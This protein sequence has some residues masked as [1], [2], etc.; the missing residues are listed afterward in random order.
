MPAA[1]GSVGGIRRFIDISVPRN[2]APDIT[3]AVN[4]RVFNVDDLKEVVSKNKEERKKAAD[5]AQILLDQEQL[6]FEAWRD[7]LETVPTI[8]VLH[9]GPLFKVNLLSCWREHTF[10]I[11]THH[12]SV[13]PAKNCTARRIWLE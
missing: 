3:E 4:G 13:C 9:T 1:S 2:I 8:K 11:R 5:E 7:S 12:S 6:T 10:R